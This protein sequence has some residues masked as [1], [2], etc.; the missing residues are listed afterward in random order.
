M[1]DKNEQIKQND[2][3][4]EAP[5]ES[6]ANSQVKESPTKE[7]EDE[8]KTA[9][10]SE[11]AKPEEKVAKVLSEEEKKAEHEKIVKRNK[12]RINLAINLLLTFVFA[13]VT[14]IVIVSSQ[15]SGTKLNLFEAL[16]CFIISL[17]LALIGVYLGRLIKDLFEPTGEEDSTETFGIKFFFKIIWPYVFFFFIVILLTVLPYI[18]I[19]KHLSQV[20]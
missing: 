5:K 1:D 13:I 7:V 18:I 17:P 6:D 15:P 11:A 8:A 16:L 2:Q 3:N 19:W 9:A 20:S 10:K 14:L 12:K 4:A